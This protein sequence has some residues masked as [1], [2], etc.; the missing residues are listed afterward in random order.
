[1]VST[2]TKYFKNAIDFTVYIIVTGFLK[3]IAAFP[4]R[5]QRKIFIAVFA[6]IFAPLM[7]W[8]K[9]TQQN[10]ELARPE[11]NSSQK[12]TIIRQTTFNLA[13]TLFEIFRPKYLSKLALD[14]ELAGPG[15][16]ILKNTI[17]QNGSVI[18]VSGHFGNYDIIRSQ[19]I[20]RGMRLGALYRPLNNRWLNKSYLAAIMETGEPLFPRNKTGFVQMLKH[21]K[22]GGSIALLID[23]HMDDGIPTTFFGKRVYTSDAAAKLSL[24]NKLPLIPIYAIRQPTGTQF[25]IWADT[26]INFTNTKEMTQSINNSLELMV[27]EHMDQ[28]SWPHKRWKASRRD[29]TVE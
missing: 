27:R 25:K 24:K 8:P 18:L 21:I 20:A 9:R 19:L 2:P 7:K 1:M 11:L 14:A 5:V 3:F 10:L 29:R 15:A 4:I 13:S 6:S 23:Q 17:S 22:S 26:P 28:W 12:T 16:N